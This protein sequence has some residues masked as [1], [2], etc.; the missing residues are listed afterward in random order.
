MTTSPEEEGRGMGGL[1]SAAAVVM[2]VRPRRAAGTALELL[3]HLNRAHGR[4]LDVGMTSD[5]AGTFH[6]PP[7]NR[8]PLARDNRERLQT[9]SIQRKRTVTSKGPP[10][11]PS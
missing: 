11:T 10:G 8:Q 4:N 6:R 9:V 2:S 7:A 5:K 3:H 1:R